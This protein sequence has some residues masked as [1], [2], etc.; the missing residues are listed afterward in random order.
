[1]GKVGRQPLSKAENKHVCPCLGVVVSLEG[2]QF[3]LI[4]RLDVTLREESELRTNHYGNSAPIN[5]VW[6]REQDSN[7]GPSGSLASQ[8]R[9]ARNV[10]SKSLGKR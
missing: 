1:M 2:V 3:N 9:L 6:L 4:E 8:G 10:L 5:T 7:L